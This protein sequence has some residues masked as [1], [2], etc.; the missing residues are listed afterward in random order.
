MS[1]AGSGGT[2]LPSTPT[3]AAG[4][5]GTS[6][7]S[8]PTPAAGSG[9]TLPPPV[10]LPP[11]MPDGWLVQF[12]KRVPKFWPTLLGSAVLAAL[13]GWASAYFTARMTISANLKLEQTKVDLQNAQERLQARTTAYVELAAA[14][15]DLHS[16]FLSYVNLVQYASQHGMDK[17]DAAS[18]SADLANVGK[19]EAK[20]VKA[21]SNR[22]LGDNSLTTD[23]NA[24]LSELVPVVV[25]AQANPTSV[26]QHSSIDS[27]ISA[28][29]S[30]SQNKAYS[31][32]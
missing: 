6:L 20:V 14:L 8:T 17:K 31:Q 30:R 26:L 25:Q 16:S 18:L 11:T 32:K 4:S 7:P 19:A 24:C 22:T 13:I 12:E 27:E 5:G 15:D 21:A 29:A 3:P 10:V 1:A 23:I 2:S 28:L 9:G